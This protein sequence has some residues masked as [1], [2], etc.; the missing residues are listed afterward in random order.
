MPV[1]N[2]GA[3]VLYAILLVLLIGVLI[4]MPQL[5]AAVAGSWTVLFPVVLF[6]F[7]ISLLSVGA[8]IAFAVSAFTLG[9]CL[10]SRSLLRTPPA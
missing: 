3:R 9:L 8:G 5:G 1:F 4:V 6:L 10:A 2:P 7:D